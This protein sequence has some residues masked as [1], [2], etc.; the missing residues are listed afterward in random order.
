MVLGGF[1]SF[2]VLVTMHSIRV[3]L[4]RIQKPLRESPHFVCLN[5]LFLVKG[6]KK[7]SFI[8]IRANEPYTHQLYSQKSTW[9]LFISI[10]FDTRRYLKR[11]N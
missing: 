3:R 2:H 1:R 8:V 9:F 6:T 10:Y 7:V 5:I 11:F 4:C